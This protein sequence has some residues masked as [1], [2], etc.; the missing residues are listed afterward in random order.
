MR[1]EKLQRNLAAA[2]SEE[3]RMGSRYDAFVLKA[4]QEGYPQLARLFR[5]LSRVKS[6]HSRRFLYLMRGKIG[7]TEKNLKA[8]L[9]EEL[10]VL[11]AYGEMAAEAKRAATAVKKAFIQSRKV[12]GEC[13]EM[14]RAAARDLLRGDD[15]VYYVCQICGHIHRDEVPEN[16]PVCKAVPGRFERLI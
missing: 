3:S 16:C 13:S 12:N 14:L 8:A 2:Y 5:A 11:E 10:R 1:D 15:S 6:V 4:E 7:E 9:E